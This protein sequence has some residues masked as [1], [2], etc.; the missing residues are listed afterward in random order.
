MDVSQDTF[1]C[2]STFQLDKIKNEPALLAEIADLE[3]RIAA[4]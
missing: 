3:K 1:P 4:L 2:F